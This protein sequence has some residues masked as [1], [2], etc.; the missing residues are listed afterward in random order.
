MTLRDPFVVRHLLASLVITCVTAWFSVGYFHIDEY[1]QVLELARFKLGQVD[2]WALPW[3]Q[4]SQMRPWL[5]PWLYTMLG[6]ALGA[7]GRDPFTLAFACRLA[8]GFTCWGALVAFVGTSLRWFASLEEQRLH[9][10]VCALLGFLPYLF[11]RTSSET[12]SMAAFTAA[13]AV[14]LAGAEP[15]FRTAAAESGRLARWLVPLTPRRAAVAGALLGLSFE[16]RFQSAIVAVGF[17]A[18]LRVVGRAPVRGL[19]A[20]AAGGAASLGLGA[21]VDHW[22]Y[23]AWAFPAWTYVQANLLEGAAALFGSD[24]PFSYVWLLPS[25]VFAPVVVALLVLGAVAC[26]RAPNHPV[27]WSAVPFFVVHNVLSHKEERFLFP[28]AILAAA[29]VGLALA[30]SAGRA[31]GVS[32]WLWT[33]RRSLAAK[34]LGGWSFAGMA[35]LAVWP[36]GWHHHVRFQRH[37][38]EAFGGELRAHALP[39]F[40]LG[41]PAFHERGYDV[42]KAPPEQI[43]RRLRDGT[44]RTWL[45]TDSPRLHTGVPEIDRATLIWSELPGYDDA[46][47]SQRTMDIVDAYNERARPPLRKL[48]FRSLFRLEPA[49]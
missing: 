27:V 47:L 20:L 4:S 10:R 25:N 36:L 43:A 15:P 40:D 39:D 31:L 45:V 3:E 16:L 26:V 24:P 46:Q 33:R 17:V 35:L 1:F 18:W 30:P 28:L 34:M 11:V 12:L 41:L 48:H 49:R 7:A 13:F 23:G 38:H 14:A 32:T 9:V 22:G 8:T 5:Q 19:V 21:I 37:I 29:S 42:E 2:A 6:R 44:A